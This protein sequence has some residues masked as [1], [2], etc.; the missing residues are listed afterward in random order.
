[1][2]DFKCLRCGYTTKYKKSLILHINK[3]TICPVK[4]QNLSQIELL[5]HFN[6]LSLTDKHIYQ[7]KYC[8]KKLQTKNGIRMH[9]V[10]CDK[11]PEQ[12]IQVTKQPEQPIKQPEQVNNNILISSELK[13]FSS[14][15]NIVNI[16]LQKLDEV[17]IRTE[18]LEK[19]VENQNT[20]FYNNKFD[21]VT[22][23]IPKLNDYTKENTDFIT[24]ELCEI[25][26]CCR[27]LPSMIKDVHFSKENINNCNI[28]LFKNQ[29]KYDMIEIYDKGK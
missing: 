8:P 28:R 7:C 19:Q 11:K 25:Y 27:N 1:M 14:D 29:I 18:Y 23:N 6:N 26:L 5:D 3:Q 12:P 15:N 2:T 20:I 4:E 17:M 9:E 24:D 16:L 22:N 13:H 21:I 10:L